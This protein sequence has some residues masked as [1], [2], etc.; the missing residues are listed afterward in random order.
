MPY[1]EGKVGLL[2]KGKR[3]VNKNN[4]LSLSILSHSC[5]VSHSLSPFYISNICLFLASVFI[6]QSQKYPQNP[7]LQD[8]TINTA[9][10]KKQ[11][12]VS[13]PITLQTPPSRCPVSTGKSKKNMHPIQCEKKWSHSINCIWWLLNHGLYPKIS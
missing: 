9:D 1:S 13:C 4:S 6:I 11:P 2:E 8:I 12:D 10:Q 3:A 5:S 7:P